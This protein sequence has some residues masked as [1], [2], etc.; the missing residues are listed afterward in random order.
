[1]QGYHHEEAF[2][3]GYIQVSDIHKVYY[4]QYGK[5]DG[6]TG[7]PSYSCDASGCLLEVTPDF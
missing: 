6:K 4:T 2:D 3:E 5:Q 7:K 1:M